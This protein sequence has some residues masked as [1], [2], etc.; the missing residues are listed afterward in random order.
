MARNIFNPIS[1]VV[2]QRPLQVT[3]GGTGLG[4]KETA[5][6]AIGGVSV[7]LLDARNGVATTDSTGRIK[8]E[9]IPVAVGNAPNIQGPVSV[10]T[11]MPSTHKITNY[12]M[13]TSYVISGVLGTV[14]RSG[15]TLT[16]VAGSV[17]GVGAIVINGKNYPITIADSYLAAPSVTSPLEGAADR[18]LNLTVT[19]S[20]YVPVGYA[21]TH[22]ST[23]W[24]IAT[25]SGFTNV[26][27][28]SDNDTIN[29]TSWAVGGLVLATNY[30]VRVKQTSSL[31]FVSVWSPVVHFVTKGSLAPVMESAIL[32]ASDQN[33]YANF[34][35]SVAISDDGTIAVVGAYGTTI[36]GFA[37]CGAVYVYT[38]TEGVWSQ[39]AEI[40]PPTPAAS[41]YF[42]WCIAM[43]GDGNYL[44]V[45]SY[46]DSLP[47]HIYTRAGSTWSL[48]TTITSPVSGGYFGS[49]LS[50]N[51]DGTRLLVGAPWYNSEAGAAYG[52]KRTVATW[53]L[54]ISLYGSSVNDHFGASVS[55]AS[56]ADIIVVAATSVAVGSI[57]SVGAVYVYTADF[58]T[59][60]SLK[61]NIPNPNPTGGFGFGLS[62]GLSSDGKTLAVHDACQYGD[63]YIFKYTTSWALWSK[64]PRP[65]NAK[66][67]GRGLSISPD[68]SILAVGDMGFIYDMNNVYKL[69]CGAVFLY[70]LS[71]TTATLVKRIS[72]TTATTDMYFGYAT[73]V[74][75]QPY[76]MLVGANKVNNYTGA[77]YVFS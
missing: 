20:S 21:G 54:K 15:D 53:A 72:A 10:Y 1:G 36:N 3:V 26:I 52:Y 35:Q 62:M 76:T 41:K 33:T 7:S 50:L 48:Q 39:T 56:K 9:N 44:A 24:Q 63:T 5:V 42:G 43:S 59:N 71:D 11:G 47:V 17:S 23:T 75:N 12:D 4:T 28:Y 77:A 32:T 58:I 22:Q 57:T 8:Q 2:R 60:A 14:T 40:T 29:L 55:I 37:F 65:S 31:G 68:G 64:L 73:R 30:Y 18:P 13:A 25:D 67:F 19:C 38:Q 34:G 16:Y 6:R 51:Y 46:H 69:D 27:A 45:G 66:Y 61:S 49:D 74:S 70:T